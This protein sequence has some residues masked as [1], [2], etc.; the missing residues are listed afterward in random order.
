[1]WG[2]IAAA[3]QTGFP[4]RRPGGKPA[5][6]PRRSGGPG[7]R[8]SRPRPS[9]STGPVRG[10]A[11]GRRPRPS[12]SLTTSEAAIRRHKQRMGTGRGP[13]KPVNRWGTGRGVQ[14]TPSRPVNRRGSGRGTA[15]GPGKKLFVGRPVRGPRRR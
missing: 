6:R 7:I 14:R 12:R 2:A 11:T 1:M 15:R 3:A 4:G 9:S 5:R 13:S 8:I 10:R